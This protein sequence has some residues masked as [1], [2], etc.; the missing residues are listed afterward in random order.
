MDVSVDSLLGRRMSRTDTLIGNSLRMLRAV[1]LHGRAFE[2]RG[3]AVLTA[4]GGRVS[5]PSVVWATGFQPGFGWI[6]APMLDARGAPVHRRGLKS[7]PRLYFLGL[8]WLHTRG[9]ALMGWMDR[10]AEHLAGYIHGQQT[11]KPW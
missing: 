4:D 1:R 7:A 3:D 6:E 10:D 5:P 11:V 8:S 2:V 9:S